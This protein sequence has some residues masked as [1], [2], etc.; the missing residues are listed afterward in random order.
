MQPTPD[1][2]RGAGDRPEGL[3]TPRLGV[4]SGRLLLAGVVISELAC[5]ALVAALVL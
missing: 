2:D 1:Q 3:P 4:V 5:F